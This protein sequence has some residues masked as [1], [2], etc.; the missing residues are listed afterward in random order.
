[1]DS[2]I[3]VKLNF[4]AFGLRFVG[5]LK[6]LAY[7]ENSDNWTDSEYRN[8]YNGNVL[9]VLQTPAYLQH[10]LIYAKALRY[11]INIHRI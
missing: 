1:M 9:S 4:L 2:G 10:E 11:F 6:W 7:S 5:I 8:V 3:F